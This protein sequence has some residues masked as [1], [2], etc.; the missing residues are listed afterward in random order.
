MP[1]VLTQLL[2]LRR[3][4]D[5]IA[6]GIEKRGD[7]VSSRGRHTGNLVTAEMQSTTENLAGGDQPGHQDC[8]AGRCV[9]VGRIAIASAA[10]RQQADET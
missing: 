9:L 5:G 2:E 6:A 3:V 1:E 7:G 10:T 4:L 8:R